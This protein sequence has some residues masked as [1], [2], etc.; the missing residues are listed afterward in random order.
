MSTADSESA[1]V[2]GI[3]PE[4]RVSDGTIGFV[5]DAAA[6]LDVGI[7]LVHVVPTMVGGPTGAGTWASPSTSS[8]RRATP[9]WTRRWPGSG[10]SSRTPSL[11]RHACCAAA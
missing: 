5:V 1:I 10:S 9:G 6:R 8:S 11:S 7:E 2:V 4:G 3:A